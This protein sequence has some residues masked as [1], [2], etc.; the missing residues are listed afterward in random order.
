M[1]HTED[2][3]WDV[4]ERAVAD[5]ADTLRS[6]T[7]HRDIRAWATEAKV[8]TKKLWPKV[9]TELRKQLDIDYD[10]LAADTVAREAAELAAS[11]DTAPLIELCAAG[12]AEVGSFAVCSARDDHE[13]WYGEFHPQDRIYEDGDDFSAEHAAADKAV[14]L[15]GKVR[16]KLD[17]PAVRLTVY[18]SHPDLDA[19]ALSASATRHR[20]VA[21]VE[22]RDQNS[23]VA[24]CRAPGYRTWR[25]IRLPALITPDDAAVA[26]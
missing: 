20:V 21:S 19:D 23:A 9:K 5:G 2:E 26:S 14:F 7:T 12:D 17:L 18:S 25:E 3:M 13:S 1:A 24:L 15:A 8:A 4:A 6:A 11:A 22:Y 16:E 10:Q